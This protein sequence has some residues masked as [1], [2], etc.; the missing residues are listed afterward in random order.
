[1]KDVQPVN[2]KDLLNKGSLPK[3]TLGLILQ[4]GWLFISV[5]CRITLCSGCKLLTAPPT[6]SSCLRLAPP[7]AVLSWGHGSYPGCT[8]RRPVVREDWWKGQRESNW[9]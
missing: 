3:F 6:D 7:K 9:V 5:L 2:L 1:M 8:P 4:P